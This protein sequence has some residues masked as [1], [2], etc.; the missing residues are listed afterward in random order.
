MLRTKLR[1][2]TAGFHTKQDQYQTFFVR[3]SRALESEGRQREV[4]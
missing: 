4:V 3:L 1:R 2:Q